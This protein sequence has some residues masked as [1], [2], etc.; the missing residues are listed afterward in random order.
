MDTDVLIVGA[1]PTGLVLALWLARLGARVR[2]IDV[3]KGPG[4]TSR[5]LV[6]HARIL[7]FY[8]QIGF[9]DELIAAGIKLDAVTIRERAR[10]AG[11]FAIGNFGR[12][13]SPFPF[14]LGLP[15]DVHEHMLI[16]WLEQE[17]VRVERQTRFAGLVQKDD[18]IVATLEYGGRSETVEA[19]WLC[20]ADGA[21]SAVRH[22]LGVGF[23]GGK[24]PQ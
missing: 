7:E 22:A 8:R 15:Q 16:G 13:L 14:V 5:A 2:I 12:G 24:Y 4:E 6:V 1:G 21:H 3:D 19:A 9:A 20:G 11:V 17:G 23:A 10:P 18:R